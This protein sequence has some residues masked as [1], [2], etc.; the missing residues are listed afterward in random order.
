LKGGKVIEI[1]RVNGGKKSDVEVEYKV[2][3]KTYTIS[4]VYESKTG[5]FSIRGVQEGA[6]RYNTEM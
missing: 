2:G 6:H 3:A 1:R 5:D 4:G